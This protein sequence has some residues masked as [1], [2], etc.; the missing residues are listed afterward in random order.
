MQ[1]GK[2][3]EAESFGQIGKVYSGCP[4]ISPN[5][6]HHSRCPLTRKREY[7]AENNI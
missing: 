5:I 7:I 6:S 3:I 2:I 4:T 1:D